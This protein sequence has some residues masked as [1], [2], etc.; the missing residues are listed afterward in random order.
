MSKQS[1]LDGGSDV[2]EI[3]WKS[4]R[5]ASFEEL[6]PS[7]PRSNMMEPVEVHEV[8]D[9]DP[10]IGW[11]T[12]AQTEE[13]RGLDVCRQAAGLLLQ[14]TGAMI[15]FYVAVIGLQKPP[16]A[17]HVSPLVFVPLACWVLALVVFI[18]T[19]RPQAM[20]VPPDM[21]TVIRR[22]YLRLLGQ[23]WWQIKIATISLLAG[24]ACAG[25]VVTHPW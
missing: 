1:A 10:M 11:M 12:F 16:D 21:P 7:P 20:V 14:F 8:A 4:E 3:R 23:K 13:K 6:G 19:I 25:Y 2:C 5:A 24:V 15:A 17:K 18:W 9:D 22:E